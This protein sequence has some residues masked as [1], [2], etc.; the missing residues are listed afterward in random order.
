MQALNPEWHSNMP[1][2]P[3]VSAP[4]GWSIATYSSHQTKKPSPVVV[5]IGFRRNI[6]P[7]YIWEW[8]QGSFQSARAYCQTLRSWRFPQSSRCSG[9]LSLHLR[10]INWFGWSCDLFKNVLHFEMEVQ[11]FSIVRVTGQKIYL[12]ALTGLLF[13]YRLVYVM[14]VWTVI[15]QC[16]KLNKRR[17]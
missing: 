2:D 6:R 7:A 14:F 9:C 4:K 10:S 16:A 12:L 3:S 8:R 17:V 13:F 1:E 5:N 11:T 15:V